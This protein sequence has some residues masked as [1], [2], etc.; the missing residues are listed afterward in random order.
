MAV[1]LPIN[2]AREASNQASGASLL[3]LWNIFT[4]LHGPRHR[5]GPA[6]SIRSPLH[7]P[8]PVLDPSLARPDA[9]ISANRE[10]I[11]RAAR[12]GVFRDGLHRA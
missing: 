8:H 2:A 6:A 1:L 11:E 7:R 5:P 9:A 12:I 4:T 10:R 3:H